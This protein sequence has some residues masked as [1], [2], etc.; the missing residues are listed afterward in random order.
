MKVLKPKSG[1]ELLEAV[2]EAAEV[3]EKGGLVIVPTETVYGI[4]SKLEYAEKIYEVKKRP[5]NKPLPVQTPYGRH[6]EV[7]VFDE[8]SERVARLLWPGPLTLVVEA[9]PEVPEAVT[10]GTG[11]VGVRVPAHPFTLMLLEITGPLAVTSANVSG[12]KSPSRP[13][14]VSVEADLMID[15]GPLGG[16]PSTVAEVEGG[17]VRILREGPIKK[18]VL[19]AILRSS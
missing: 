10:A 1:K 14:E 9:R 19:E 15:V 8:H 5:K 12:G 6:G 17:K 7:G 11:K 16:L 18:E 4:A 13:E 3:L 2:L